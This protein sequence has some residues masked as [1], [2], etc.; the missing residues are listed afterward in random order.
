[1]A[2]QGDDSGLL[3]LRARI[4]DDFVKQLK[5]DKFVLYFQSIVPAPQAS[6]EPRFREILVR[7]KEEEQDLLPPGSF[8]PILE[9]NGL[10]PLLDRWV[11]GRVMSW[12]RDTQAAIAPR[13]IPR[14]S[15]NLSIDTVRRDEAFGDYVLRGIRKMAVS[16]AFVSFE[17][18]AVEAQ[19]FQHALARMLPPLR[20]A[21]FAFELSGFTGEEAAFNLA[22]LLGFSWVKLDGS[23]SATIAR[24][25]QA[26]ARL[27]AV[28][29]RCRKIGI[30]TVCTQIEDA[31]TLAHLRTLPVDYV[32]GFG[33]DRPRMLEG[34]TPEA[35]RPAPTGSTSRPSSALR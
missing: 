3:D 1:M 19:A 9:E 14:C 13:V 25:P 28:L 35:A 2:E 31:E 15:V 11:V 33:I 26:K 30:K 12:A 24:D 34:N 22:T 20:S 32:Q 5:E 10:M 23:L 17:V 29:Q 8:L 27:A 4:R 6:T 7:Y 18:Q 21:G 16:P